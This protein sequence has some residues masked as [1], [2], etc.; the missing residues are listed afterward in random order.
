MF[1]NRDNAQKRLNQLNAARFVRF[2]T[3]IGK[4]KK[5]ARRTS[6]NDFCIRE[7]IDFI[8]STE[9]ENTFRFV[10]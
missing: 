10:T 8:D 6:D 2:A 4:R 5:D 3:L 1:F 7:F 9:F